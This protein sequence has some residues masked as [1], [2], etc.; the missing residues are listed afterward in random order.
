MKVYETRL[1]NNNIIEQV[2][3]PET[4]NQA[5]EDSREIER[6]S[7]RDK[8]DLRLY[9]KLSNLLRRP[10]GDW[11]GLVGISKGNLPRDKDWIPLKQKGESVLGR[12]W[13]MP[14]ILLWCGAQLVAVLLQGQPVGVGVVPQEAHVVGGSGL[15]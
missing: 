14:V 7:E 13:R 11:A 9:L 4:K 1:I 8:K 3:S 2:L 12:V 15:L 5:R 10:R 6:E